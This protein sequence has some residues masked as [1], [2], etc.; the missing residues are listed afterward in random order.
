MLSTTDQTLFTHSDISITTKSLNSSNLSNSSVS[1]KYSNKT[2]DSTTSAI[3]LGGGFFDD[4]NELDRMILKA[5][6]DTK[7]EVACYLLSNKKCVKYNTKLI[8]DGKR[9]LLH[10]LTIYSSVDC[11]NKHLYNILNDKKCIKR[12]L[13]KQDEFGNTPVHYAAD[14]KLCVYGLDLKASKSPGCSLREV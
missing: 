5:F 11:I 13:N 2:D 3:Q 12:Q 9:N 1:S 7:A 8:D 6:S 4:E 10:Y 14:C